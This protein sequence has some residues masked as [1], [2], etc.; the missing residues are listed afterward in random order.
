MTLRIYCD[1]CEQVLDMRD[2][3]L[4]LGRLKDSDVIEGHEHWPKLLVANTNHTRHELT[5]HVRHEQ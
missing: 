5:Y 2:T 3:K 1:D 4:R